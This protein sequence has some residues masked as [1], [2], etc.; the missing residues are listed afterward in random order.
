MS[1]YSSRTPR[2]L[3]PRCAWLLGCVLLFG[4]EKAQPGLGE[5]GESS[6]RPGLLVEKGRPAPSDDSKFSPGDVVRASQAIRLIDLPKSSIGAQH[7][8]DAFGS[9]RSG[10]IFDEQDLESFLD[11]FLRKRYKP[12]QYEDFVAALRGTEI[13]YSREVLLLLSHTKGNGRGGAPTTVAS[14]DEAKKLTFRIDVPGAGEPGVT[15]LTSYCYPLVVDR[16]LVDSVVQERFDWEVREMF[17]AELDAAS[18][19]RPS[20]GGPFRRE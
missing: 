5:Q 1:H 3:P 9:L 19:P 20:F 10:V 2:Y 7:E 8:R 6:E 17:A 14:L 12:E 16:S 4:C 18:A 11:A 13:D 15:S